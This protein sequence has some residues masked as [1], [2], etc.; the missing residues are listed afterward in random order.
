M[1]L[2]IAAAFLLVAVVVLG[3]QFHS[4]YGLDQVFSGVSAVG[5]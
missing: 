5:R 2:M 3:I 1:L 4:F